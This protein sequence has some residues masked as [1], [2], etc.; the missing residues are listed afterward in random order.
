MSRVL[1]LSWEYPPV[2][3][4]GLARH[5]RKLSEALVAQGYLDRADGQ[6]PTLSVSETGR[7][8]LEG[9]G[10][11]AKIFNAAISK[12]PEFYNF[13]IICSCYVMCLSI[14]SKLFVICYN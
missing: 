2:V 5:V 4:G 11:A 6:Y 3:E 13:Y 14:L 1:I 12:D 10:A 8:L 9:E 7:A